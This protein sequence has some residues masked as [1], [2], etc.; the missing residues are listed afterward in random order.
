MRIGDSPQFPPD[1]R[2]PADLKSTIGDAA[3]NDLFALYQRTHGGDD[4]P[5]DGDLFDYFDR[6]VK[7]VAS[8]TS[9][10][11]SPEITGTL[12]LEEFRDVLIDISNKMLG[13]GDV[14]DRDADGVDREN[15]DGAL[16]QISNLLNDIRAETTRAQGKSDL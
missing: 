4:P 5:T 2:P 1:F 11:A 15:A 13:R 7:L 3:Y 8:P 16:G 10:K 12:S 6:A 9:S 14:L